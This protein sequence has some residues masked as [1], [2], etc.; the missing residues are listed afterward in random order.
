MPPDVPQFFLPVTADETSIATQ[1][2]QAPYGSG[3]IEGAQ[4]AYEPAIIG[5]ARVR[6]FDRQHGISEQRERILLAPAPD[7][8][9]AVDWD[10][11]RAL[12][13]PLR[14]LGQD[15]ARV[16]P[17][18]GPFFAPV[19]EEV[20]STTELKRIARG[21]ADW[22]YYSSELTLLAHPEL[23]VLQRP[24]E[25]QVQFKARL[26]QAARERRDEEADKLRKA[27]AARIDKLED[28]LRKEK[29]ELDQDKAEYGARKR[30]VLIAS[31]ETLLTLLRRR[32][33]YRTMSWT[34]SRRR[35]AEQAK[36]DVQE[37]R[38]E[39]EDLE[40]G[41]SELREDLEEEITRITPSW[42]DILKALRPHTLHPRRSDIEVITVG[43]AWVPSWV[44]SSS[45]GGR[46]LSTTWPA[47]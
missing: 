36:M 42:L 43:L 2:S 30:E 29:R 16:A 21:F 39:M 25:T 10:H 40:A 9:G 34:A 7:R 17:E 4:L 33:V 26:R 45:D 41:L 27:Y 23:E 12:A 32:R 13:I 15:P 18:R 11:S 44:I 3:T 14:N 46:S 19:P 5:A 6:F 8:L 24:D 20:N 35:L 1:L 37:S 31:G 22:L 47:Y 38:E 28:K